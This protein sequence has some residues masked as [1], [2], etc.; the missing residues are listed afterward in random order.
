MLLVTCPVVPSGPV[1]SGFS[2]RRSSDHDPRRV[3]ATSFD[4]HVAPTVSAYGDVP[5]MMTLRAGV[6]EFARSH[7]SMYVSK[8]GLVVA[9][10]PR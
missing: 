10:D 2:R 3:R 1:I 5:G 7:M 9:D 6:N 4:T 8:R